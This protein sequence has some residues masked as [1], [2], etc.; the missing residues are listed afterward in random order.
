MARLAFVTLVT[1][2][3]LAAGSEA[4]ATLVTLSGTNV[5]FIIDDTQSGLALYG[6]MPTVAGDSLLFF[7]STF[8]AQSNNGAGTV[9]VF[10]TI[11]FQVV[12]HSGNLALGAVTVSEVGDYFNTPGA[13]GSVSAVAQLG[14]I[15][16]MAGNPAG[17]FR[18]DIEQT[19]AISA[20]GA[21]GWNLV[22]NID[23]RQVWLTPTSRTQLEIQN[24]LSATSILNPSE[25][26]IQKKFEGMVVEVQVVP[27]PASLWL[28]VSAMGS[29]FGFARSRSRTV[30]PQSA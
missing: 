6:G 18:Q 12:A 2:V 23:F 26:W 19:G 30:A 8:R 13:G 14:A 11:N 25:S 16:L 5:D 29:W 3:T 22:T 20:G 24:N 15:N 10:A 7:P 17:S 1:L 9:S 21:G 4:N 28:L 27:L